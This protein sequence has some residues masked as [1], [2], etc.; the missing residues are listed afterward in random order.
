[1]AFT[2]DTMVDEIDLGIYTDPFEIGYIS[3]MSSMADVIAC[4]ANLTGILVSLELPHEMPAVEKKLLSDGIRRAC[5]INNTYLLGGDTNWSDRIR[6]GVVGIGFYEDTDPVMRTGI[7]TGDLLFLSGKMGGGNANALNKLL[8]SGKYPGSILPRVIGAYGKLHG[9]YSSAGID[10]SDGFFASLYNLGMVNEVNFQ[11]TTPIAE[12]LEPAAL[13][14]AADAKL[15]GSFLLAGPVG[16]YELLFTV[17]ED[18]RS[19][20]LKDAQKL[21]LQV[22]ECGRVIR[23]TGS[24]I[25]LLMDQKTLPLDEIIEAQQEAASDL[26]K[27]MQNL[28]RYDLF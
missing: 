9:T 21:G 12:I 18:Q 17:S 8:L 22:I 1:M 19:A 11:V 16:E 15:P 13:K 5:E 20:L 4:G 14:M 25:E 28:F 2:V 23:R 6:V 3:A 7:H 24:G 26:E 10:T 27:V